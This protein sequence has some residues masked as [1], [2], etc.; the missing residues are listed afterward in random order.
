M[1]SDGS[2]TYSWDAENRLVEVK[3]GATTLASFAYNAGGIR[4]SKTAGG[5]TTTYVLEGNS[6]VEER[7]STGGT[8]K[9]LHGPGIDDVLATIDAAG[10]GSY[11]VRDH[12][13]SIRQRTDVSGQPAV[14]RDYDPW[15]NLIAGAAAGSWSFTGREWDADTALHYYRARYYDGKTGRFIS[16]DPIGLAG[17]FNLYAYVTNS[18]VNGTD[19]S[20]QGDPKSPFEPPAEVIGSIVAITTNEPTA[21]ADET[22]MGV[23]FVR[24]TTSFCFYAS[25]AI[26][27]K[28]STLGLTAL[29]KSRIQQACGKKCPECPKPGH[30][31]QMF[32]VMDPLKMGSYVTRANLRCDAIPEKQ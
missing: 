21:R 22:Q 13:G 10:V 11:Y 12:L 1:T 6:V 3:Q 31:L 23:L 5:V 19:P 17:G 9:H 26:T 18:P 32:V 28:R 29:P 8:I 20:G 24:E 30:A 27:F 14:T 4:T 2:K 25:G 16:E 15:G 7:P